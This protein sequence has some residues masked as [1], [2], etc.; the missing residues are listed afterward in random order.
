MARDACNV[1]GSFLLLGELAVAN[2]RSRHF[3]DCELWANL[4]SGLDPKC[5]FAILQEL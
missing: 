2:D 1:N 4:A 3:W 5:A